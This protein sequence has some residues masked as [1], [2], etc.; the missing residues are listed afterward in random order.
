MNVAIVVAVTTLGVWLFP[1]WSSSRRLPAG[2]LRATVLGVEPS[3]DAV[4]AAH[5]SGH[6]VARG[7][8]RCSDDRSRV[9][10]DQARC[11]VAQ[12]RRPLCFMRFD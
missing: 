1:G 2:N 9:G 12:S 5:G 7:H 3:H 8:D 4:S 10:A 11:G 6:P